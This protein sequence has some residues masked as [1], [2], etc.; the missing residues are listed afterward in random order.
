MTDYYSVLG[1]P[2]SASQEEIKKAYRKGALK[3]HPDKNPGDSG[4]ERKF[5]EVSEAYEILSNEEKK[6]IYDQYGA[7]AL[8]GGMGGGPRGPQGFS[9]MEEALR[10]FMGAFGGGRTASSG[11]GFFDSFFG[12]EEAEPAG[13][14]GASKKMNLTISFE[15]AMRGVE[16]EVSLNNYAPCDVCHGSGAA[17]PQAIKRCM[18]CQGTGQVHQTRGFFS[19]AAHCPACH[20]RGKTISELCSG[21]QGG[22]RVKKK[23]NINLK[24]PAGVD[25]G[26]CLRMT[27]YGDAGE[28]GAPA[29]D[30]YV[31]IT[32]QPSEIFERHGDDVILRLPL[33]I[34][35]AAL[36][37]KKEMPSPADGMC[38]ITIPEGTQTGKVFRVG[39]LGFPNV[40]GQGRGDL[41][42][43]VLVEIPVN[44]SKEQKE[45]LRQFSETEG[46]HNAP[47]KRSFLDKLKSIFGIG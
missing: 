19:V 17:S 24:V 31:Y 28:A 46:P 7:D 16:K 21:C 3:Y 33:S 20:G 9:S 36:G 11:D 42:I 29:G 22:G 45:I 10:T 12:F 27:G 40:H 14:E 43:E 25:T 4:A 1:V 35:E 34:S 8:K 32:V 6:R 38:R 23:K 44:L 18:R 13:R 39:R 2:K 30:L 15:E 47:N 5:K 26:T 41:L 37:C